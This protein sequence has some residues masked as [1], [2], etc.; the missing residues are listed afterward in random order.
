MRRL[1]DMS[2]E[3]TAN[4]HPRDPIC[5]Y[6]VGAGCAWWGDRKQRVI[7]TTDTPGEC[8]TQWTMSRTLASSGLIRG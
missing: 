1:V 5:G 7:V 6:A 2:A 3:R 8:S 4:R